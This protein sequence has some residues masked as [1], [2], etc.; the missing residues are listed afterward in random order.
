MRKSYTFGIP[1]GLQRESG[2]FLDI[3]EVSRGIDCN[4]ICPAC[5]TDL[6]AKQGEVKL[7]HFSAWRGFTS[8]GNVNSYNTSYGTM[9]IQMDTNDRATR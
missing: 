2:L 6:L 5:K 7:W 3:T 8:K 1:F 9:I 4:C